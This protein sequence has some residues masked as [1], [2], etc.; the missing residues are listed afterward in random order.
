MEVDGRQ[1]EVVD[2]PSLGQLSSTS[3]P[4][5]GPPLSLPLSSL[6]IQQRVDP[7]LA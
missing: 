1:A 6:P 3:H 7:S 2:L 4:L 5:L